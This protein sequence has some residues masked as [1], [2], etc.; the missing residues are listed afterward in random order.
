[1]EQ[2]RNVILVHAPFEVGL[3]EKLDH[4]GQRRDSFVAPFGKG[5]PAANMLF[6]PEEVHGASGVSR[7]FKL[8]PKRNSDVGRVSR[9]VFVQY[10]A[11][12][13]DHAEW[14][15]AIE[16]GKSTVTVLPGKS[17]QTAS[18]SNPHWPNHFC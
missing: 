12:P 1:L 8:F 6:R 10:F 18:D 15:A 13:Q 2:L 9:G 3:G 17:R 14:F 5:I 16:A 4:I 11:V 7:I